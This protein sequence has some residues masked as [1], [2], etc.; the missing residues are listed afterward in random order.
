MRTPAA[1]NNIF[2]KINIL[3]QVSFISHLCN[4]TMQ[5][6]CSECIFLHMMVQGPYLILWHIQH[7]LYL[8]RKKKNGRKYIC[9]LKTLA[10]N[11]THHFCSHSM[12]NN[13][14]HGTPRVPRATQLG[15]AV[16]TEQ[17]L[18]SNGQK[19]EPQIWYSN[20]FSCHSDS[21]LRCSNKEIFFY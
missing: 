14:P 2:Q 11:G 19:R 6:Y 21:I 8:F 3:P 18:S 7:L 1:L 13:Q 15:N 12:S 9:C 17:P 4:K 5:V 20:K 16:L 10:Q